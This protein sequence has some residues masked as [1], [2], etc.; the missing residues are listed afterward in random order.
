VIAVINRENLN[1]FRQAYAL[2]AELNMEVCLVYPMINVCLE[3]QDRFFNEISVENIRLASE[4]E[5]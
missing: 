3:A 1:R 4:V 5:A 2:A